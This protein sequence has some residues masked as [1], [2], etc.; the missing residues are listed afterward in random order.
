VEQ[1]KGGKIS[2]RIGA[3]D[4]IE[5]EELRCRTHLGDSRKK[6]RTISEKTTTQGD[7]KT[8]GRQNLR[9]HVGG[10][11]SVESRKKK[12]A[13]PKKRPE[14]GERG[15]AEV[16]DVPPSRLD[17]CETKLGVVV[18]QEK[19]YWGRE[20][21]RF[22]SAFGTKRRKPTFSDGNRMLITP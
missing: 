20:K 5:Q 12:R 10:L 7:K 22:F 6:R 11:G 1:K 18:D 19:R 8:H 3:M 15:P 9:R 21:K 4:T 13:P 17:H 2:G 14:R 16:G